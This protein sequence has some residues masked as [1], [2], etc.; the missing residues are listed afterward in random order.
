MDRVPCQM[1]P[2]CAV[3]Q[4]AVT[5]WFSENALISTEPLIG[6]GGGDSHMKVTGMLVVSLRG[7]N[8]RFWSHVGCSGQKAKFFTPTG[9]A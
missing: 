5:A 6:L 2:V 8:C 7:V 3:N 4:K 9:I 1:Q